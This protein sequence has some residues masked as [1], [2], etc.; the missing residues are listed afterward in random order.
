MDFKLIALFVAMAL[1]AA[2][3]QSRAASLNQPF[4]YETDPMS[5]I[6]FFLFNFVQ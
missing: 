4:E 1:V 3:S 6:D 2:V 5:T